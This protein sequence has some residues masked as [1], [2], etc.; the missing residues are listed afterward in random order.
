M[1]IINVVSSC[2]TVKPKL[3][4]FHKCMS[5]KQIGVS[6]GICIFYVIK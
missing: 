1:Y 6:I 2:I 4:I 5:I 3:S